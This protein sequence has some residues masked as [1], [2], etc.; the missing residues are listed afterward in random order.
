MSRWY[1]EHE[2]RPA[3]VP[4]WL[5]V[6]PGRVGV[7]HSVVKRLAVQRD[8]QRR[9]R[10]V[11]PGWLTEDELLLHVTDGPDEPPLTRTELRQLLEALV[12]DEAIESAIDGGWQITDAAEATLEAA[13]A[14]TGNPMVRED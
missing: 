1:W 13:Y 10:S 6:G 5:V 2:E 8:M 7:A 11:V 3:G 4:G 9:A 12:R 14:S